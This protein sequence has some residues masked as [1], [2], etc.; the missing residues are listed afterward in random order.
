MTQTVRREDLRLLTGRGH[1][2]ADFH[3]EGELH[4]CF[5]R[6]DR[7]HARIV[8][9]DAAIAREQ[10]GVVAVYAGADMAGLHWPP[11]YAR[12][13]GRGGR[14][15]LEPGRS[16]IAADRVR[17]VGELVAMIVAESPAIAQ[18]AA[19]LIAIEYGSTQRK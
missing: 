14:H 2:V 5:L 9:I 17:F 6:S 1:Y 19:E 7:A 10:P 8:S 11:T 16:L 4:A 12:F 13:A 18:D 15:V 3:L